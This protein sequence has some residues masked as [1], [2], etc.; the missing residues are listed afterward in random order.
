MFDFFRVLKSYQ[1][2]WPAKIVGQKAKSKWDHNCPA[3]M[4]SSSSSSSSQP[5]TAGCECSWT[6]FSTSFSPHATNR[7]AGI[8]SGGRQTTLGCSEPLLKPT[9]LTLQNQALFQMLSFTAPAI[10]KHC[11]MGE[12]PAW[13]SWHRNPASWIPS[14]SESSATC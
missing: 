7:A 14:T 11:E 9:D 3:L 12:I 5:S 2:C 10:G 8:L 4:F 6:P 1:S 13:R